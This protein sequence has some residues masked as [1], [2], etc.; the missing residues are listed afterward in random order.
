MTIHTTKP[1]SL[2][3]PASATASAIAK[4]SVVATMA[5]ALTACQSIDQIPTERIASARLTLANGVPAGTAQLL[6]NGNTLTLAIAATGITPGEHGFH[7]HTVGE[8]KRPDFTSAG[9][10]LNPTNEGHGLDD[11]DGSHL[12]DLPN[13]SVPSSGTVTTTVDLRGSRAEIEGYI[14]DADGTAVM[15]HADPDDGTSEPSGNAG[16]RIACGVLTKS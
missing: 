7:L 9:G 12:G 16:D 5:L 6:A 4:A 3:T 10:H 1:N 2:R 13:L 11:D 15:I 14:F 8:C